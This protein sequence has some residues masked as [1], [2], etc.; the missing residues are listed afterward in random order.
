[1]ITSNLEV[2]PPCLGITM[3]SHI[4]DHLLGM[5]YTSWKR[6]DMQLIFDEYGHNYRS[7]ASK[8]E[9]WELLK[10]LAVTH[11]LDIANRLAIY[12]AGNTDEQTSS[13]IPVLQAPAAS[14]R[15]S[16]CRGI[17]K[18]TLS[19]SR[20]GSAWPQKVPRL[21]AHPRKKVVKSKGHPPA[22]LAD[23][24]NQLEADEGAQCTVC[25]EVL[26]SGSIP[27]RRITSTCQHD[28]DICKDCLATSITSQF[29]DKI[30]DQVSCPSCHE[31]LNYHDMQAFAEKSIF[32][33]YV[34]AF[35]LFST[36]KTLG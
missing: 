9:L 6:A 7:D 20:P 4:N 10:S 14:H 32:E 25:Y 31:R 30:W 36:Q 35:A 5:A 8:A 34:V 15:I 18:K 3:V 19:A 17:Q 12:R 28:P 11:K 22:W 29:S 13:R 21:K 26:D 16:K 23:A 2:V 1:M 27:E 24:I 33:R